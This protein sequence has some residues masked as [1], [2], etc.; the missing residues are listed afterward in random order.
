MQK[1]FFI[2][3]QYFNSFDSLNLPDS[4][5]ALNARNLAINT[6]HM[7]F[8]SHML[9]SLSTLPKLQTVVMC[10]TFPKYQG[11]NEHAI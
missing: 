4:L 2:Y 10:A 1:Y 5:S 11:D 9:D 6:S 8:L 3:E 7:Q